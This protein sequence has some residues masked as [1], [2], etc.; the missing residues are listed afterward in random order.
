MPPSASLDLAHLPREVA[1][2]QLRN[3]TLAKVEFERV[4]E[5][6]DIVIPASGLGIPARIYRLQGAQP[7]G[8]IVNYHGGGWVFG[9]LEQ[10]DYLCHLIAAQNFVVISVDYRLAPEWPFPAPFDDCYAAAKWAFDHR[11]DFGHHGK[12]AVMGSSAGGNLAAA[13]SYQAART[14]GMDIGCQV[15]LYPVCSSRMDTLSYRDN[16]T[17]YHLTRNSMSWFWD[18][19]VPDRTQRGDPRIS[20]VDASDLSRLPATLVFAAEFDPLRDEASDYA[21]KLKDA[22]SDAEFTCYD[23]LIH[24]FFRLVPGAPWV[25][26]IVSRASAKLRQTLAAS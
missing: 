7:A 21:W 14:G 3:R 2:A 4:A 11:A 12:I 1:I 19:Y 10:D 18:L 13:V 9:S 17:G 25:E 23:G 22:G 16:A 26:D 15:L 6:E 20:P 8:V 5:S 24:G